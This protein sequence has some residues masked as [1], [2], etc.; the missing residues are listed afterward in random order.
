[1]R[2]FDDEKKL[3]KLREPAEPHEVRDYR[4]EEPASDAEFQIYRRLYT[5]DPVPL[6]ARVEDVDTLEHWTREK[7]AFDLPYG[8]RGGAFLYLSRNADPP[9]EVVVFWGSDFVFSRDPALAEYLEHFDFL[10]KSGIAV[11]QPIFKGPFGR[12][13]DS[14]TGWYRQSL[15]D[16]EE[17]PVYVAGSRYRDHQTKWV[18]ELS[19]TVDY[20]ETRDDI[21]SS[22]LGYYSL[23]WGAN[24]API[25]LAL[26]ERID[27]AV[28]VGGGLAGGAYRRLPEI[29][30]FNFAPSVRVPVL[31]LNGEYDTVVPLETSQKPMYRLLGTEP[32]HKKH[33]VAPATHILAQDELIRETLNW[34]D[35]YLG[36]SRD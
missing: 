2:T 15:Y 18:Q 7:V 22:R 23:S 8:E 27:A 4:N 32:E 3:A 24:V 1:M 13:D 35:R 11:A 28:L 25:A 9:F 26:E 31:M 5:Y 34:F 36:G 10:M 14:V 19:R 33:Y 12:R 30:P 6:N 20:L 21:D 29:D 17:G 16:V